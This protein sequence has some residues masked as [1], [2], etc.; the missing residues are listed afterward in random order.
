MR[1]QIVTAWDTNS[2]LGC[3]LKHEVRWKPIA[4]ALNR[5]IQRLGGYVIEI[6]KVKVEHDLLAPN[7]IDSALD[8][9]YWERE[10]TIRE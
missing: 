1:S 4:I 6:G 8:E 3:Q 2:L 7:Q 5:L 9:L 10:T